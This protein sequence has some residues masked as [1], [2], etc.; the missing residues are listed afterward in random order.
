[1][2]IL[3]IGHIGNYA[4]DVCEKLAA[5][6]LRPGHFDLRFA[7]PLDEEMLHEIMQKYDK[8]VTVED[9]CLQGGFGSAVL[10]FMA[11][12][13]YTAKVRRLGIPDK[14]FEH[15]SQLQLQHEA[16]FAPEDIE[17]AVRELMNQHVYVR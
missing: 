12:H 9:G 3:T 15:G 10:E 6:G 1:M 2:A 8:I 14:Y 4:V 13:D 16:G 17:N 11:D 7:K 5:E